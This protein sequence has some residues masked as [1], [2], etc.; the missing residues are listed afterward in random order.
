MRAESPAL[1]LFFVFALHLLKER[2]CRHY[3]TDECRYELTDL[4]LLGL[5]PLR[6]P[7]SQVERGRDRER[8]AAERERVA[9][10]R[11]PGER[12]DSDHCTGARSVLDHDRH[13]QAIAKLCGDDAGQYIIAAARR[14]RRDQ[15]DRSVW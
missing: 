7:T 9:V 4:D 8:A 5:D 1:L 2:S 13:A 3:C 14:K 10:R 12:L 11:G 6:P 15:S